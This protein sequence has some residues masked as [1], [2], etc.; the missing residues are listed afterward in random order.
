MKQRQQGMDRL[1]I[2]AAYFVVGIH[3]FALLA[4]FS[5]GAGAGLFINLFVYALVFC[6]VN[7]F[8]LLSGYLGYREENNSLRLSSLLMLWMQ[9]VFYRVFFLLLPSLLGLAGPERIVDIFLPVTRRVNWYMTAYFEMMLFAPAVNL[10]IR[11]SS[12][13]ANAIMCVVLFAFMSLST[14]L[15]AVM[16][17]DPFLLGEGYNWMWLL[18]LYFWGASVKKHGWFR[19]VPTGKLRLLLLA[20][21]LLT[22]GWRWGMQS[23]FD[24]AGVARKTLPPFR[25][26]P[27]PFPLPKFP[28]SLEKLFFSYPSPTVL[29]ASLCLLLLHERLQ[30]CA[31]LDRLIQK[32]SSAALGVFL[33]H[34]TVWNWLIAPRK[35]LLSPLPPDWAWLN[36]LL[37]ALV[38]TALCIPVDLMRAWLFEKLRLRQLAERVQS[39]VFRVFRACSFL[40]T[41]D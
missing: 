33:L 26:L 17:C 25:F 11:H 37:S 20:M 35:Q 12:R 30:P 16:N 36:V 6:A 31:R 21:L 32:A 2:L 40:S 15:R 34:T 19:S 22:A 39:A 3:L 29:I 24:P 9:F 4:D 28:A 5:G 7:C 1:R 27:L 10:V 23:F 14:P 18:C 38:I 41:L 13:S 8:G